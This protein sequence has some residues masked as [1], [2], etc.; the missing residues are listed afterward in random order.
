MQASESRRFRIPTQSATHAPDAIRGHCFAV[1][2]TAKDYAS[3]AVATCHGERDRPAEQRIVNRLFRISSKIKHVVT[4]RP[5][6][7][8]DLL[9]VL[10]AGVIRADGDFHD[11]LPD[12]VRSPTVREGILSKLALAY[13]RA[14]DT[15]ARM[16]SIISLAH[17]QIR[18]VGV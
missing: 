13:A 4:K 16:K 10:K 2:G 1:A 11:Q 6:E 8:F 3:I 17:V 5:E 7:F 15:R 9:F 18:Y 14:S 12:C